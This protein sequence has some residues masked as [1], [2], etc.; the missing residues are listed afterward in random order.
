MIWV[1][2]KCL[3]G[4]FSKNKLINNLYNGQIR[5]VLWFCIFMFIIYMYCCF[6]VSFL[7]LFTLYISNCFDNYKIY[8]HIHG[9]LIY[10]CIKDTILTISYKILI[11]YCLRTNSGKFNALFVNC[12]LWKLYQNI[13]YSCTKITRL[14]ME[15]YKSVLWYE[16]IH[17]R[18]IFM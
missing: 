15:H 1:T 16:I 5:L 12:R 8:V 9:I 7:F 11:Y 2:G 18:Y 13:V 17:T 6:L 4:P 3:F 14:F 10:L